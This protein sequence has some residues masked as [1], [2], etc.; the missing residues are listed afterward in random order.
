MPTHQRLIP[1]RSVMTIDDDIALFGGGH[2]LTAARHRN[3]ESIISLVERSGLRGRGGAGF[4][5]GRKWRTIATNADTAPAVVVN[6]AEGEPG[7]FKDRLLLRTNPYL[8]LEGACIAARAMQATEIVI[9][10]KASFTLELERLRQAIDEATVAG[11][12]D[13][14]RVTIAEGPGEYLFGEETALLE[15]VEGRPPFPRVIPPYRHGISPGHDVRDVLVAPPTLVDNVETLANIPGILRHGS[16]WFRAVGTSRS[17]GT[18]LCTVTG[19]TERHGVGEFAIGTP[20]REVLETVGGTLPDVAVVLMGVSNPPLTGAQLELPLTYEDLA[21]A[22]SGLGSATFIVVGADR[23]L[24]DVAA[25]VGRF[26]AVESCGQCAPCKGD[27]A[28]IATALITGGDPLPHLATVARGARCAL[29][30]QTERVVGRLLELAESQRVPATAEAWPIVPLVDIVSGRALL[31][32]SHLHKRLDW[33]FEGEEPD[34]HQDP[35]QRYADSPVTIR[36]AHD[37]EPATSSTPLPLAW[38]TPGAS[39]D[40]FEILHRSHR[41]IESTTAA[42]RAAAPPE[43]DEIFGRLRA[44]LAAHRD[45][46]ERYLYPLLDRL[47]PDIGP[48]VTWYPLHHD[49][50][51][52]RLLTLLDDS[53]LPA[54]PRVIDEICADIHASIIEID[55]RVIPMILQRADSANALRKLAEDIGADLEQSTPARQNG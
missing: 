38:S 25:G 37:A 48:S 9:A 54:A 8:V 35:V 41:S 46:V 12:F 15:V 50:H 18:I 24:H 23:S 42:L 10:V 21:A 19:D 30:G 16:D 31:D 51:A 33:S 45:A 47:D 22:G 13:G 28:A 53:E 7:T 2:G 49:H 3:P 27:G 40:P 34:S 4:P 32:L 39:A 20:L 14:R 17:P 5:T 11:W 52:A 36:P 55:R 26:L 1:D 43:R 29:A 44:E 6:A